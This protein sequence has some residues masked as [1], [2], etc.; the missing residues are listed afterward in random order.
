M[1]DF[2]LGKIRGIDLRFFTLKKKNTLVLGDTVNI[3]NIFPIVT[4]NY[5][6]NFFEKIKNSYLEKLSDGIGNIPKENLEPLKPYN[7]YRAIQALYF[8]TQ[9]ELSEWF[10]ELLVK[11]AD[12]RYSNKVKARYQEILS[13]LEQDDAKLLE[14]IFK[15]KYTVNIK[16]ENLIDVVD[17]PFEKHIA[18]IPENQDIL[19]SVEGIPFLEIRN[20][21]NKTSAGWKTIYKIFTDVNKLPVNKSIKEVESQLEHLSSLGLIE[22]KPEYWFLPAEIY[23]H[24][25]NNEHILRKDKTVG[26]QRSI[27]KIKGRI[28]LT[29]LGKDFLSIVLKNE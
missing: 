8:L 25:E 22:I 28:D 18:S 1:F 17:K 11:S 12:S 23:T 3:T 26:D 27:K 13:V 2:I 5:S 6:P 14:F 29:T 24:L 21:S 9:E 7:S 16:K 4:K 20:D 15:G 19:V 10:I